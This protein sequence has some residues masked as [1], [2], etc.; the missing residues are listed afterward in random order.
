MSRSVLVFGNGIGMALDGQYFRLAAGLAS[1]WNAPGVLT[2]EQKELIACVI[3]GVDLTNY[4]QQEEQLD[5]MQMA[6]VALSFLKALEKN[7]IDWLSPA[8]KDLPTA[9]RRFVHAAAVYFH[10]SNH[11]LPANFVDAL[12]SYISA[13]KSHVGVLN[14]DNLLYDSLKDAGILRGYNGSLIDGFHESGF[15]RAQMDRNYPKSL[16]WYLHLH[17]SPLFVGNKKVMREGRSFLGPTDECHIVLT[18]VRHKPSIISSSPILSEYWRR[19]GKAL[20]E[21]DRVVLF[22]YAGDDEHLNEQ[23]KISAAGKNIHVIEWNGSGDVASRASYWQSKFK[24]FS[25]FLH[26]LPDILD[27]RDWASLA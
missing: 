2:V 10:E 21:S 12:S 27:F 13:T 16:G 18:H 1:A 4:P 23:I 9:F 7:N 5:Q 8:S 6:L 25:T 14:Y 22:G 19:L 26:P 11:S 24:G 20:D 17:G 15:A 3:P